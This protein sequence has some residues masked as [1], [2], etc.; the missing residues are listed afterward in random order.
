M[1]CGPKAMTHGSKTTGGRSFTR[2]GPAT[3]HPTKPFFRYT[4]GHNTFLA[5]LVIA[6]A[7]AARASSPGPTFAALGFRLHAAPS[8][9][10]Q[11]HRQGREGRGEDS[12][13]RACE[14]RWGK[15]CS[16]RVSLP[17]PRRLL[18]SAA[19]GPCCVMWA[20]GITLE[21]VECKAPSVQLA[22]NALTSKG[23]GPRAL[24]SQRPSPQLALSEAALVNRC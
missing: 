13:M 7:A 6:F 16:A 10:P 5:L 20:V 4:V 9:D 21:W 23:W 3:R 19:R 17:A 24:P 1:P 22:S 11:H 12:R 15:C 18:P 2:M 8:H 14:F